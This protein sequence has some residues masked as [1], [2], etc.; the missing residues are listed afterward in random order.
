MSTDSTH[1]RNPR[2]AGSPQA[3]SPQA[4]ARVAGVL[5]LISFVAGAF[6]EV[7][8][9]SKLMVAADAT[10]TAQNIKAL[11][12][13]FRLGFAGYLVEAVCDVALALIFYVLLKPVSKPLALLA[14]FFNLMGT[15]TFAAAELFYLAPSLI[16]KGSGYLK[17]FAPD[18]LNTLALLSLHLFGTGF[19]MFTVFYGAAWAVRGCLVFRSG[20]LPKWLGVLLTLGGLGYVA[21]NFALVLAPAYASAIMLQ[22]MLPGAIITLAVWLLVRGVDV[23]KWEEALED[24][25]TKGISITCD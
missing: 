19:A 9:P 2:Q 5:I 10:A 11:D 12:S 15:A 25:G 23:T 17:T 1:L 16:L 20:Y 8:V 7:Y 6:G 18:Q 21:R 24:R 3:G 22:F 13:L 4:V 14:A